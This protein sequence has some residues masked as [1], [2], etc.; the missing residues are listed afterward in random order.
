[1]KKKIAL[2]NPYLDVMGGGERHILS[3]MQVLEENGFEINI[4]WEK[5][6]SKEIKDKLGI[7]FKNLNFLPNIFYKNSI[8]KYFF[9]KK[10][11]AFF[12]VTDGS[13]FFSGAKNNFCFCMVP[14]KNLYN[15]NLINKVKTKNFHFISNSKFTQK[16]LKEWDIFSH[17]VYPYIPDI[18]FK[19]SSTKRKNII[20]NVG[21]FF[22]HLHSKRQDVAIQYFIDLKKN[23]KYYQNYE[24]HLAGQVSKEDKKYI[25]KLKK[26]SSDKSIIFHENI[27]FE[28]LINLY[29]KAKIY[30]HFAGFKIDE[31]KNPEKTEHLGIAPL[32]AMAKEILTFAYKAGGPKEYIKNGKNGF[33]FSS[34]KELFNEMSISGKKAQGMIKQAKKDVDKIFSKKSFEKQIREVIIQ[35]I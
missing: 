1:M 7:E 20:L 8:N 14:Q 21:R 2:Y 15:L 16:K 28:K 33:L 4:F 22:P 31:N 23:K 9:L 26:I 6:I 29:N 34:K 11:D 35:K 17:V 18:F 24:L 19:K 3:I 32:E 13:Y 27:S 10:F 25:E 30:W 12:Y 5:N